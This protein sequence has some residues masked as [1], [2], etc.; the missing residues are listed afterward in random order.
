MRRFTAHFVPGQ[1]YWRG[2]ASESVIELSIG[3]L[4]AGEEGETVGKDDYWGQLGYGGGR[5]TGNQK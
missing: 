4:M 1:F 3:C 5:E 2:G